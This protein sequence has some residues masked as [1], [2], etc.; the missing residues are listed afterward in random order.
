MVRVDVYICSTGAFSIFYIYIYFP[1]C[2]QL[3]V[4]VDTKHLFNAKEAETKYESGYR[5][6]DWTGCEFSFYATV[7]GPKKL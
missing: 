4:L 6:L 5:P 1:L 3:F 7:M 2:M